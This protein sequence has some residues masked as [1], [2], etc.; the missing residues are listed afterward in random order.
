MKAIG[1][2]NAIVHVPV[3]HITFRSPDNITGLLTLSESFLDFGSMDRLFAI[4]QASSK[5]TRLSLSALYVSNR[6]QRRVFI[7]GRMRSR[8]P[9]AALQRRHLEILAEWLIR[10]PVTSLKLDKWLVNDGDQ[11][12]AIELL[13]AM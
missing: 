5:L 9:Q 12:S 8:P 11:T 4:V 1:A 10:C 13:D 6:N 2:H 7:G 3:Q